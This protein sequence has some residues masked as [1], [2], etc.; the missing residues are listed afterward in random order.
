MLKFTTRLLAAASALA[1]TGGAAFAQDAAT[2]EEIVV[3]AQKREQQALD[4]P[5]S[6]SA[7]SAQR[8]ENL[9]VQ[10][11][12]DLALFT[13]GFEVQE[14]SPNNPG[15]VVR[16]ITSDETNA[17]SEARV[18]VFQ[19]GVSIS[20]AQG[21]YVELFDLER[22]EVAKGPQSTLFGRGALIGGVNIIQKKAD[23]SGFGGYLKAEAGDFGYLMG[24]GAVNLPISEAFA[25]RVSGRIRQRDGYVENAL[26]GDAFQSVDS[27]A[28][29]I[30]AHFEPTERLRS[31][32]IV[33]YQRDEPTGTAFKSGAFSPTDPTTGRVLAGRGASEP[34]ALVAPANFQGGRSL[35]VDRTVWS[36]TALVDY[37]LTD[38]LTLASISAVRRF[39]SDEVFDPDGI[40]L[41]ILTGL[42]SAVGK[43]WSQ[44]LRL[45]YDAGG[46]VRG[47]VGAGYFHESGRQRTP[48]QFDER[49]ALA[50]VAGQLNGAAAGLGLPA[51][52]P[53]PAALFANTAFTGALV[54]GLVAQTSGN[55]I[56]LSTAQ[57]SAIAANLRSNH[58]E[59]STNTS[60][61]D[62]IDLFG[63]VSFD[64][65]ERLEVSAG[66]RWTRDEK[67]TGFGTR[68][69]GGRSVIG[70]AIGAAGLA[71]SGT[72]Q[73]LAQA[74]AILAALQSPQVQLIPDTL[75]PM[76][77][78]TFQPTSADGRLATQDLE[79]SGF[80]WR[81]VGRYSFTD[82]ANLYASYARGRLPEVLA[83]SAPGTPYGAARFASVE[84]ETVDSYE[85]GAKAALLD[86]RL[87]LDGAVYFYDYDNFQTVE[88]QGTLF[89]VTNA[90]KAKAYGFEGQAELAVASGLDLYATYAYSHARFEDGAYDGNRFRLSPDH[91]VSLA[92]NWSFDAIG[93]RVSVRPSYTW[94]SKVFFGNDNDRAVFQQPPASLVADNIQDEF[95]DGYGL[96][97]LR[98]S[99]TASSAPL[100]LEAFVNNI[101]DEEYLIDAG[102]TGD[103][104]GLPTFIAG[105]P[106]MWGVGLTWKFQ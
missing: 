19:D 54:R 84:A 83:A 33:N 68:V 79:D 38:A 34:A 63:D 6:L 90:G 87:R 51:T 36:A 23:T 21:S 64:V 75:L 86:R 59:E 7:Y 8:L 29:R 39:N 47:F 12:A 70:G 37:D 45:N 50:Q 94:Q 73:G 78:V 80:T 20:K 52:T 55:R 101:A 102:N 14:Q 91:S 18:S 82:D 85:F 77:G 97:N 69:V 26:G 28:G 105:P 35:G 74:N 103:S 48:I 71:A 10:D 44:E 104:L 60:E 93:G 27:W 17:Y 13:P 5:M 89:V 65:T 81:L 57:A 67:T 32:F 95:Q 62:S 53:A 99:W 92:A 88:Q 66:L 40:S 24:E 3:T 56:V 22:V 76:F 30:A 16:G 4:V 49:M 98:V 31:D 58:V 42:N 72:P 9:G 15:F 25:L 61:L 96:A 1:L 46:R 43:Q 2:I 100:I 106:R 41:P 11:F